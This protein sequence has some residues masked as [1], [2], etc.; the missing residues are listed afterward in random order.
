VDADISGRRRQ[1]PREH[2][3]DGALPRTVRSEQTDHLAFL[4]RERDA[5]HRRT[6]PVPL[7][8]PIN[9]DE[10]RC[11]RQLHNLARS[12]WPD[13]FWTSRMMMTKR[14]TILGLATAARLLVIFGRLLVLFE[15]LGVV[16]EDHV[17]AFRGHQMLDPG[18]AVEHPGRI[19]GERDA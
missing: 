14:A 9:D 17:R 2:A 18:I 8:Q 11:H 15:G 3:Q 13:L 6:R 5:S 1:V 7:Y 19:V 12:S 10:T 4:D 16:R